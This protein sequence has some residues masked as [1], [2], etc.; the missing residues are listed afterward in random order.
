MTRQ[1]REKRATALLQQ[2]QAA[3]DYELAIASL[4]GMPT[5]GGSAGDRTL[6]ALTQLC[7]RNDG[8]LRVVP[9]DDGRLVYF[10]WKLTAGPKKQHYICY[11]ENE[12]CYACGL[13]GL[14]EKLRRFDTTGKG[15][16]QDTP[17]DQ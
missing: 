15:A 17:Y 13:V 6:F 14:V 16:V 5:A 4:G 8:W 9:R 1:D 10:L 2:Q 3:V 11:V 7:L 12:Y